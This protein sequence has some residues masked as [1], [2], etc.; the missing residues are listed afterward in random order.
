M[1]ADT[2]GST[3][4]ENIEKLAELGYDYAELPLAEIMTLSEEEFQ[5]LQIRVD[6][7]GIKC[8]VCNNF[9]P[10]SIRLTGENVDADEVMAYV[11]KA[12]SRAHSLGVQYV[13]FGSGKAKT[14]PDNYQ[15]DHGYRQVVQLLKR[16]GPIAGKNDITIVIEPLRKA[17]CNLIN[18]FAEGCKLAMDVEHGNI[19]VL[20][21]FYHYSIEQ[22][23]I[24]NLLTQGGKY[25][26]HV[27]F[28]NSKGRV[29]PASVH[30]DNYRPFI[31]ALKKIGYTQ[32]ISC[33]AYAQDF[34][35]EAVETMIF[36]KENFQ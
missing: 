9:F 30:E 17:E 26:R 14:V 23:P 13:V 31:D 15:I 33:E 28:A 2:P 12:L 10:S 18:T 24:E 21:D 29:Y 32:R 6:N 19:K 5:D 34:S 8:E 22:E 11:E 4:I 36:F 20:V 3:G 25:L 35:R 27:H 1:V 16:V 7:S